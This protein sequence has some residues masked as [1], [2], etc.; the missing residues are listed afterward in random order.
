MGANPEACLPPA[1]RRSAGIP[2]RC[3]SSS[4]PM[5]PDA[6]NLAAPAVYDD[7]RAQT[8]RADQLPVHRVAAA[9][10]E[11][12][13]VTACWQAVGD[14]ALPAGGRPHG[15]RPAYPDAASAWARTPSAHSTIA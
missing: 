1:P 13:R 7:R 5:E 4:S 9:E 11:L 3:W 14:L 6:E 15:R 12:Q 8:W 10:P 2:T